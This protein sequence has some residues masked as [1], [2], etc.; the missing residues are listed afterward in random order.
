MAG[1]SKWHNIQKRKGVQDSKRSK[2]FTIV[3]RAISA[4]VKK[5]GIP[6]PRE[7]P[8]LRLAI[9]KARAVNMPN[10]KIKRAIERGAGKNESGVQLEESLYEGYGPH[11]VGVL[12]LVRT[13]NRQRTSSEVRFLFSSY[14]GSLASPGAAS[15]LFSVTDGEYSPAIP[16][17]INDIQMRELEELITALEEHDD[18][19][20][21]WHNAVL[22]PIS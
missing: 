1:H 22:L 18:I 17:E 3:S 14:G 16:L 7:N 11:G 10:D 20:G 12:A 21:V 2:E 13:D 8:S 5:S 6:D 19:D 9:E 4:A 15:Y